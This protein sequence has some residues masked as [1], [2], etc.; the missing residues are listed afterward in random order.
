M[1]SAKLITF[2]YYFIF[3]SIGFFFSPFLI[4]KGLDPI[5][6]GYLT[7]LG[8]SLM[9]ILYFL[10][11]LIS[12]K[13]KS[14]KPILILNIFIT[15]IIFI[16]LIVF[17]NPLILYIAYT[18]SYS[19]FMV[20]APFIDGFVLQNFNTSFYNKIRSFGSLGAASSYFFN[21]FFLNIYGYQN[22][23]LINIFFLITTIILLS[24]FKEVYT[25]K[26]KNLK[27]SFKLIIKN[28]NI[29][30]ILII[31]FLT[32]GTLKADDPYSYAYNLKYVKLSPLYISIVG[33]IAIFFE[34]YIMRIY[35]YLKNKS[36]YFLLNTSI[37][38]LFIIYLS[39]AFLFNNKSIIIIG[40]IL[41]GLFIGIFVPVAIKTLN[42]NTPKNLQNTTLGIYQ[43]FISLGGVIIGLIT[44]TYL[45]NSKFLPHIYILHSIIIL[46]AIIIIYKYK[47]TINK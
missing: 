19:S 5:K 30:L 22:I 18:L 45:A 24:L 38:T 1:K 37:I 8:L 39:R 2:F 29:L 41:I 7:S 33:S 44:T 46:I 40:N 35:T 3:V 15:I 26:E 36:N 9:I 11:G 27:E 32:Y 25:L 21:T 23:I 17:K 43:M 47:K 34:A 4:Q 14:T 42:K 12:D 31:A 10:L 20:L 13:I 28:K 16:I 6:I